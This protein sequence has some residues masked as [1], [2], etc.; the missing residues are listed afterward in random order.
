M[1]KNN[2][3]PSRHDWNFTI[4]TRW[5]TNILKDKGALID[6]YINYMLIRT[7]RMFEYKNLPT[8]L[9]AREIELITQTCRF[10]IWKKVNDKLYVFY[11]GLGGI[12]N[13]YYQPTMAIVVNPFLKYNENLKVDKDCVVMWNDS[14]HIGLMPMF[15]RNASLLAETDI[16]LRLACV[17]TRLL[18]LIC[19]DNDNAKQSAESV[20]QDID[21]GVKLGV[22]ATGNLADM[23]TGIKTN[24][25]AN[26]STT[27]IKDLVE[28]HQ[29]VKATW[30]NELG[31]NS[32]YNMKR[33]AINEEEASMNED[34]LLPLIDD[35]LKQRKDA[36]K[37]V[38]EMFGYNIEVD[39][40]S[41]WK[42][43]REEIILSKE[44][45]K[46]MINGNPKSEGEQNEEQKTD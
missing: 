39:L 34:A 36:V 45:Q 33:E 28:L 19:A 3:V 44:Q 38:N 30:F 22:I 21:D 35:M 2:N 13:E 9:P 12:P 14:L 17:N 8:E 24:D 31:I 6:Q 15:E 41:S 18:T 16:S 25:Y 43:M 40:S 26:K 5:K 27:N 29:Y 4:G 46:Q 11:G 1:A 20:L 10:V 42:K 23:F 32:N 7:Q 37:K